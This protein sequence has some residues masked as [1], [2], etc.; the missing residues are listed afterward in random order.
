MHARAHLN[1]YAPSLRRMSAC[2][3]VASASASM[4]PDAQAACSASASH[5]AGSAASIRAYPLMP[6]L[7]PC[8]NPPQCCCHP[9]GTA[10][11]GMPAPSKPRAPPARGSAAHSWGHNR[12]T[13]Q[14]CTPAATGPGRPGGFGIQQQGG[15]GSKEKHHASMQVH[16]GRQAGR[17]LVGVGKNGSHMAPARS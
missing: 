2:G 17:A 9:A 8:T 14:G 10:G 7:G 11:A 1:E 5:L 12:W 4:Q 13:T 15:R 3:C 6:C 16:H